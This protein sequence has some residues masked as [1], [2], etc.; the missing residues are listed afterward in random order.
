MGDLSNMEPS[1]VPSTK[2]A[3]AK[4][5]IIKLVFDQTLITDDVREFDYPGIGT[6]QDPFVVD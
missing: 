6:T 3:P 5:G 2:P 1:L 4:V